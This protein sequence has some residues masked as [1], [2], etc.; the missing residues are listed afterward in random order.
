MFLKH[1]AHLTKPQSKGRN[2]VF[3]W[4]RIVGAVVLIVFTL[5]GV[6]IGLWQQTPGLPEDQIDCDLR[7]ELMR[8]RL[9]ALMD[10][11]P[12]RADTGAEAHDDFSNLL[13][14]THAAC[15]DASPELAI[16]LDRI[17]AQYDRERERRQLSAAAREE[18][19]AP[20]GSPR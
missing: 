15:G 10:R 13:R 18:L 3:A 14:E 6:G 9:L 16:T 20:E 11:S 19:R 5:W 17:Q 8:N 4:I 7:A 12:S 2:R 1:F